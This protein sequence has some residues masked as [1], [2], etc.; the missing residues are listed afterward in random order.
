MLLAIALR[1]NLINACR[2][3]IPYDYPQ[4]YLY[5]QFLIS[6]EILVSSIR[7]TTAIVENL[8]L[9]IGLI[10]T[11]SNHVDWLQLKENGEQQI[12]LIAGGG[13]GLGPT[14]F[15]D[16]GIQHAKGLPPHGRS[17]VNGVSVKANAGEFA[18][19]CTFFPQN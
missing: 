6:S 14:Q 2:I 11:C 12:L 5:R 8:I 15:L 13:G 9:M 17:P 18:F 19:I 3:S 4:G 10:Q 1:I 16:D 7:N